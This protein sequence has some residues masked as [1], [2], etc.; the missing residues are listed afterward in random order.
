MEVPVPSHTTTARNT[1][2]S[3]TIKL[4]HLLC[5]STSW[6]MQIWVTFLLSPLAGFVLSSHLPRRASGFIRHMLFPCYFHIGCLCAFFS[7][8]LFDMC[9]PSEL[10][11]DEQQAQLI[12]FIVCVAASLLNMKWFGRVTS[13]T[14]AAMHRAERTCG[15]DRDNP[16][17]CEL[18]RALNPTYKQ[19]SQKF[20][21]YHALSSLC[22]FYCIVCNGLSLYN[23]AAALPAL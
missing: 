12:L 3:N 7:L 2:P 8:S 10:L 15:L 11:S 1:E 5:L 13:E 14:T 9:R 6:G 18:L 4:P 23:V 19:L 22:N 17:S 16:E 21:L 20:T